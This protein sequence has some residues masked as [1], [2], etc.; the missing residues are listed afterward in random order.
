MMKQLIKELVSFLSSYSW[1]RIVACN[2][3]V[4]WML[5]IKSMEALKQVA[6]GVGTEV[7]RYKKSPSMVF[8]FLVWLV[9]EL[10]S[11]SSSSV[12]ELW[13]DRQWP[14]LLLSSP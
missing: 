9:P 14:V 11:V 13:L 8:L 7:V 5:F 10:I 3:C 12:S 4:L 1:K 2:V 6:Q